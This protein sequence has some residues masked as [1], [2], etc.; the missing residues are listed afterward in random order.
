M[1]AVDPAAV[2]RR[3]PRG[4]WQGL[5]VLAS[6]MLLGMTTWFSAT[7]VVPQLR[8]LWSLT[9]GQS[10]W[11][12]ISVQLGFVVGALGSALFNLADLIPPR[13][14]MLFGSI[15]AALANLLLLIEPGVTGAMLL[16]GLTGLFLAGVYPPAMKAMATWF[17]VKRGTALGIMVGALTLGSATPHLVNGLGG[18]DWR[19]VILATSV[20]TLAGGVIAE[21]LGRDGPFD[22]PRAPF[23]PGQAWRAFSDRPVRLASIGYFGH[24]WELYA[25]WAWFSVFIT[26]VLHNDGW[27]EPG[28]TGALLAFLVIAIGA[29]GC[30]VGGELGDRWG[31]GNTTSAAMI[32]SGACALLIGFLHSAPLPLVLLVGLVWGFAVVADSAQFS[33]VITELGDQQYV[34]TALTLQLAIG[35][36]LTVPTLWLIPVVQN[37]WG[38]PAAFGLLAIGPVVG[39]IAMQKLKEYER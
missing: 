39:T 19:L 17:K 3:D 22:F 10:A 20:L 18:L 34:G 27:A 30:W 36:V 12:T 9:A 2:I 7:A 4:C 29:V 33:T 38:W 25:M 5:T 23:N 26:Q 21:F 14:L 1:N 35:F 31:R 13:R 28:G 15:G 16:R 24:M 32:V 8:D 11:M 6:A 37:A